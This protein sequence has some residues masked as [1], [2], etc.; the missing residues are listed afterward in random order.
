MLMGEQLALQ[1][2][3]F[4]RAGNASQL[5]R[6]GVAVAWRQ[7]LHGSQELGDGPLAAGRDVGVA[8]VDGLRC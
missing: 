6:A 2:Q 3:G 4:K 1:A 7:S 8:V 5:R